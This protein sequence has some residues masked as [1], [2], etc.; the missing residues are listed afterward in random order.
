M[1]RIG[2][3]LRSWRLRAALLAIRETDEEGNME[4]LRRTGILGALPILMFAAGRAVAH[5]ATINP[6]LVGAWTPSMSDCSR[7]FEKERAAASRS[8]SL[9]TS[10]LK[11]QSSG[12][13]KFKARQCG[14]RPFHRPY[15]GCNICRGGMQ[16]LRRLF[17]SDHHHKVDSAHQIIYSAT[18]DNVL[19]VTYLKCPI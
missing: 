1:D 17:I 11:P 14:P 6:A 8:S 15:K 10:S 4:A 12:R 13:G 19:N 18:G 7:L 16:R 5:S 2:L 9:S 3:P